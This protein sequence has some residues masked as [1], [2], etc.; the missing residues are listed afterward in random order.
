MTIQSTKDYG[1][2]KFRHDNRDIVLAHVDRLA[3]SIQLKNLLEFRPI[4]VNAKME[5]IDGQ[6]RL[7][8]AKK[9]G[10]PIYY[11]MNNAL[12][13][14]DIIPMNISRSWGTQDIQKYYVENKYP[15]YLKLEKFVKEQN[16]PLK[17]A[18]NLTMGRSRDAFEKFRMG[19][20]KF[21]DEGYSDQLS[22]CWDTIGLIKKSNGYSVYT[23]SSKFWQAM[24]KMI[25]HPRFNK[26]IW[27][28]NIRRLVSKMRPCV[29]VADYTAILTEIHNFENP[30]KID[31]REVAV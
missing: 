16:L 30:V 10:V 29:T 20:F 26:Q 7:H 9:L 31:L 22:L 5:V 1:I 8:A 14:S 3:K 6:H 23:S 18:L 25:K 2:F 27:Q 19:E 28:N 4:E 21:N 24:V 13:G 12:K 15:E 11:K 17:I